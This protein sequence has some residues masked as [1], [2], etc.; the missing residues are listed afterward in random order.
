MN[1]RL[2]RT[3]DQLT[4]KE[5][6]ELYSAIYAA[7]AKNAAVI[8]TA[9]AE[10]MAKKSTSIAVECGLYAGMLTCHDEF[11]FGTDVTKL[12][13]RKSRLM[14]FAD[15]Y[16]EWLTW[17]GDRYDES[18]VYG[19]REKLRERGI[20]IDTTELPKTKTINELEDAI[21]AK[22]EEQGEVK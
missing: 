5:K 18:L 7:V 6:K 21:K 2:P 17:A 8:V 1:V 15:G 3:Y 12:G 14:T 11:G 19:L 4:P 16:T 22:L 13:D 10:E 20:V 9:M